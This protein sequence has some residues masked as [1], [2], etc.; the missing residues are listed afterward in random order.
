MVDLGLVE[1][2]MTRSLL[3]RGMAGLEEEEGRE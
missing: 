1:G 3:G 2:M